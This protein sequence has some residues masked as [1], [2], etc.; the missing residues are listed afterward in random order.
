ML[1]RYLCS[2][3]SKELRSHMINMEKVQL[4]C[5]RSTIYSV[6]L[7]YA[8]SDNLDSFY[9]MFYNT[10]STQT[11]NVNSCNTSYLRN[12]PFRQ[13]LITMRILN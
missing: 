3:V 6:K 1:V 7:V 4:K 8:V 10:E 11:V 12:V 9:A 5:G 2:S 13:Q